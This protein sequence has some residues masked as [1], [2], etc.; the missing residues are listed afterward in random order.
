M[1]KYPKMV[2]LLLIKG[3]DPTIK[4]SSGIDALSCCPSEEIFAIF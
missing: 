4:N 3:A 2:E 1:N